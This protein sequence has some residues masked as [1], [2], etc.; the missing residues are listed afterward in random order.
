MEMNV[1]MLEIPTAAVLPD[2]ML[3]DG[4]SRML[5]PGPGMMS[6]LGTVFNESLLHALKADGSVIS[7]RSL[8]FCSGRR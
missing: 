3:E 5:P 7:K 8:D 6:A 2:I 4:D 1:Q